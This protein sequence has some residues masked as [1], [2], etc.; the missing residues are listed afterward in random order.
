[1]KLYMNGIYRNTESNVLIAELLRAGYVEVKEE[2]PEAES[3]KVADEL[4]PI[5]VTPELVPSKKGKGKV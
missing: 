4:T 3:E 1:M 2:A 5:T